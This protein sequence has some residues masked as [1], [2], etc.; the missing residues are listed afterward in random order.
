MANNNAYAVNE[1]FW[2]GE[3]TKIIRLLQGR[4]VS[5]ALRKRDAYKASLT[6]FAYE[7]PE[8]RLL[9]MMISG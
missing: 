2:G 1:S 4:R 7:R 6:F 3:L 8:T 9:K 5:Y